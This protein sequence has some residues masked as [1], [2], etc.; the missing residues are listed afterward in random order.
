VHSNSGNGGVAINGGVAN[1]QSG[2]DTTAVM[3]VLR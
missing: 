2:G 1:G 3:V